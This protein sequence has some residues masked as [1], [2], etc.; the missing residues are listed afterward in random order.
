MLP[1]PPLANETI[2]DSTQLKMIHLLQS[3][4]HDMN[5]R[6]TGNQN[7]NSNRRNMNNQWNIF[8]KS[9]TPAI[10]LLPLFILPPNC[11]PSKRVEGKIWPC[12]RWMAL[13]SALFE[14]RTSDWVCLKVDMRPLNRFKTRYIFI[15]MYRCNNLWH[16]GMAFQYFS[17]VKLSEQIIFRTI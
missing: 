6:H 3:I 4:Q 8:I 17:Y 12:C 2:Q 16:L 5:C 10:F 14:G 1:P 11:P 9:R 7:D 13:N 15:Y